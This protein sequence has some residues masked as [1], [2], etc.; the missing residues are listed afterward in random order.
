M[1]K[2]WAIGLLLLGM[3]G[4]YSTASAEAYGTWVKDE[5]VCAE[6]D[7]IIYEWYWM[8]PVIQVDANTLA[9]LI[10]CHYTEYGRKIRNFPEPNV[11]RTAYVVEIN[12]VTNQ[13][14]YY[15]YDRYDVNNKKVFSS[16]N[17]P[18]GLK[19]M[20]TISGSMAERW[21]EVATTAPR[22]TTLPKI[23]KGISTQAD[24]TILLVQN[25]EWCCCMT[26]DNRLC[27]NWSTLGCLSI[28]G[29]LCR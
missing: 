5:M 15:A 2:L 21:V 14:R 11:R 8:S 10:S 9:M 4:L 27:C 28:P 22:T 16:T 6:N 20:D 13:F 17:Y 29:C 7:N 1:K 18:Y 19:W 3:L 26:D 25:K 23:N 24:P 12:L